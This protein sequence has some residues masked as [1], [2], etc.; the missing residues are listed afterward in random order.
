MD[1]VAV[2]GERVKGLVWFGLVGVRTVSFVGMSARWSG[3]SP[4][5]IGMVGKARQGKSVGPILS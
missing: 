5:R 1:G 3:H 2:E 4:R